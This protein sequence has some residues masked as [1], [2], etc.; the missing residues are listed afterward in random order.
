MSAIRLRDVNG[1]SPTETLEKGKKLISDRVGI[2][3]RIATEA[4]QS[5]DPKVYSFG[6]H[7]CDTSRF[8]CE[9]YGGRSGGAGLSVEEALAATIG[10]VVERYC[11]AFYDRKN[12]VF[13]SYRE[14]SDV[15]IHPDAF[16][17]FSDKQYDTPDFP[18]ARFTKD[19]RVFWTWGYS[20]TYQ[21]DVLVPACLV[22]IPYHR[23]PDEPLI[24]Y[25][26]STGMAAGNTIEEAIL[27]GIYEVI[28]RDCFTIFWLRMMRMPLVDVDRPIQQVLNERF[29]DSGSWFFMDITNDL[30]IPSFFALNISE[31]EF[32]I[33]PAVGS[34]ARLSPRKA[35][36]KVITEIGQARPYFRY[37]LSRN[38]DWQ[39]ADDFSNVVD[40]EHHAIVYVK[41]PSLMS[42]FDFLIKA[43]ERVAL[44]KIPDKSTGR[45]LGDI[46]K[47]VAMIAEKGY[48]TIVVDLTTADI[49]DAGL[50][51]VR[52]IVPGLVPLHGNHNYPFLGSERIRTVPEVLGME[53]S[54]ELNPYPHPFP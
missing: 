17:L 8:H 7:V 44:G 3:R 24:A 11:A 39:P 37:E 1:S 20:L 22:Y 35:I 49:S 19:T 33:A 36:L 51:A 12:M 29:P 9:K 50:S 54:Q 52:I 46:E 10:E 40:F 47:C 15:A 38:A 43:K 42:V 31:A 5:H 13:A 6:V 18:F 23:L 4:R 27:S 41:K 30:G 2:I 14:I 32:G 48:E 53:C 25:S 21:R 26:T 34:A 16:A 28:E 45:I